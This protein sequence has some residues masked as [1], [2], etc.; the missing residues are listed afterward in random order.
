MTDYAILLMFNLK[1]FPWGDGNHTLFH[2]PHYNALPEGYE[3][4]DHE[5]A[6]EHH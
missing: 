2:N 6:G 3:T 1:P 4:P 5:E